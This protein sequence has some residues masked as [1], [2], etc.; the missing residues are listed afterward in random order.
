MTSNRAPDEWPELCGDPLLASAALDRLIHPA[1]VVL[2]SGR[3]YRLAS[4][5]ASREGKEETHTTATTAAS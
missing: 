4:Q 5:G 1:A 3:S 2:I